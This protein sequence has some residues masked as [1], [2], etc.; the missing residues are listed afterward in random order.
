MFDSYRLGC[1]L[2]GGKIGVP[3]L[4]TDKKSQF[5]RNEPVRAGAILFE[6]E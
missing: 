3:K 2:S 4:V 5:R 6:S 1:A